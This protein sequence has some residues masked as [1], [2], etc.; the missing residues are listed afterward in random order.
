MIAMNRRELP[1]GILLISASLI[2]ALF[3]ILLSR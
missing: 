1:L 3:L 2:L